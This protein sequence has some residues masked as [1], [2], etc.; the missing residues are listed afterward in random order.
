MTTNTAQLRWMNTVVFLDIMGIAMVVPLLPIIGKEM[1]LSHTVYGLIGS[2]YGVAQIFSGP[3][4]GALSDVNGR[5]GVFLISLVGAFLAYSIL[6]AAAMWKSALLLGVSRIAIGLVKQTMT[7]ATAFVTDETTAED[8]TKSLATLFSI[9]NIGFILGAPIGGILSHKNILFPVVSST[10]CYLAAFVICYSKIEDK[11]GSLGTKQVCPSLAAKGISFSSYKNKKA[12]HALP[13][14]DG[15]DAPRPV[16][17]TVVTEFKGLWED[18]RRNADV[19]NI[20]V[21]SFLSTL[22]LVV[23]Q[24]SFTM[25]TKERFNLQARESSY[26]VS[27]QAGMNSFILF[28]LAGKIES[29]FKSRQV[30]ISKIFPYSALLSGVSLILQ[31]RTHSIKPLLLLMAVGALGDALFKV[32]LSAQFTKL[33]EA[34]IGAA[35]GLFGNI[36]AICR[37]IAPAL[38]GLLLDSGG[39]ALPWTFAGALNIILAGFC[40]SSLVFSDDEAAAG[41]ASDKKT[42]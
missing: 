17:S 12:P 29:F 42:D 3:V 24:T 11:G 9:T 1:G 25:V 38:A 2:L 6:G 8:R 22:G 5:K 10:F 40:S 28:F 34:E 16:L 7:I 37:V 27:Y 35:A 32:Y 23:V 41:L 13:A 31:A 21:A 20:A 14:Q 19:K 15:N 36:E 30:S 33:Y 26:L 39:L 4:M 18:M